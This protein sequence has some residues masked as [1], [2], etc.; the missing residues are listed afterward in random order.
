MLTTAFN[1]TV[2]LQF[3]AYVTFTIDH[4][5]D[6]LADLLVFRNL[7]TGYFGDLDEL[8]TTCLNVD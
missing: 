7:D 8:C 5:T 4:D 2:L 3:E 1:R 6:Y